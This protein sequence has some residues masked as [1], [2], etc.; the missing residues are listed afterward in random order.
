MVRVPAISE[1]VAALV[2]SLILQRRQ[3]AVGGTGLDA[4]DS[5]YASSKSTLVTQVVVSHARLQSARA[6]HFPAAHE[7]DGF[8]SWF[9]S[10]PAS[11]SACDLAK[12]GRGRCG[13][14]RAGPDATLKGEYDSGHL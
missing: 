9:R 2:A 6:Q 4:G 11:R 10:A 14:R 3:G 12:N 13:K 8:S 1:D 7:G 5:Y